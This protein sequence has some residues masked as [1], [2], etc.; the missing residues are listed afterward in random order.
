MVTEYL[1]HADDLQLARESVAA[2]GGRVPHILTDHLVVV[3]LPGDVPVES[4]DHVAPAEPSRLEGTERMLAETWISRLSSASVPSERHARAAGQT[5]LA[6]DTPGYA[7]PDGPHEE[8][9]ES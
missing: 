6:W 8:G 9:E 7:P 3:S 5:P 1:V 2:H 4:V